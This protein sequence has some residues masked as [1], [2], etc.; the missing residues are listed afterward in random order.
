[1]AAVRHSSTHTHIHTHCNPRVKQLEW[2]PAAPVTLY[3]RISS[4]RMD[5]SQC[6]ERLRR[7]KKGGQLFFPCLPPILPLSLNHSLPT[8]CQ[9]AFFH[10][11]TLVSI[12]RL[13]VS[14]LASVDTPLSPPWEA[15]NKSAA[16]QLGC[17]RVA[18]R[19]GFTVCVSAHLV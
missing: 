6:G 2:A 16:N 11:S 15:Q 18:A 7:R 4:G 5:D 13:T 3:G 17:I 10:N 8:C 1:M 9:I 12:R 14:G 19:E